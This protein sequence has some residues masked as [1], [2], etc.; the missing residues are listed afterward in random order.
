MHN[1]PLPWQATQWQQLL[2]YPTQERKPHALLLTG[3]P[4]LGKAH[5]AHASSV[6]RR[7][8]MTNDILGNDTR[9]V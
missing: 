9:V 6:F 2:S 5:F 4:G 8:D 1:T 3:E 7:L